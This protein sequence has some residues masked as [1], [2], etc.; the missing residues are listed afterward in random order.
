MCQGTDFGGKDTRRKLLD[1]NIRTCLNACRWLA[2]AGN[3]AAGDGTSTPSLAET[4]RYWTHAVACCAA[5][6]AVGERFSLT[7]ESLDRLARILPGSV[8]PQARDATHYALDTRMFGDA[9][10]ELRFV[11]NHADSIEDASIDFFEA[12]EATEIE[13][14]D[15][16]PRVV[17]NVRGLKAHGVFYTPRSVAERVL[18]AAFADARDAS[19]GGGEASAFPCVLDPAA[20]AGRFLLAA[21]RCLNR[22][23]SRLEGSDPSR[24]AESCLFGVDINPRAVAFART[25]LYLALV[26]ARREHGESDPLSSMP[27][28]RSNIVCGDPL[29]APE[30]LGDL[31]LER[32]SGALDLRRSFPRVFARAEGAGFDV[33]VANPPY[34]FGEH[35][36]ARLKEAYRRIYCGAGRQFDT[37]GLFLERAVTRWLR[38]QGRYAF[39]VPDAILVREQSAYLRRLLVEEGGVDGCAHLGDVFERI[40][41]DGRRGSLGVSVV[42]V[43][44]S[45][46]PYSPRRTLR[47]IGEADEDSGLPHE[48]IMADLLCRFVIHLSRDDRER[49]ESLM[50]AGKTVSDLL[51]PRGIGRGEETGKKHLLDRVSKGCDIAVIAGENVEPF[52][53]GPGRRYVAKLTPRKRRLYESPKILVVKTG[54]RLVAAR[55]DSGAACL[56]SVYCLLPKDEDAAL[57]LE[58]WLNSDLC[59]WVV[60]KT[61]TAYKKLMPQVTQ[62]ELL[63]LPVP[64]IEKRNLE[65]LRLLVSASH[66]ES[67]ARDKRNVVITTIRA[68]WP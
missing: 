6:D 2:Q 28:L 5:F 27:D 40:D 31:L 52:R 43:T 21:F 61:I 32:P 25:V 35:L 50:E 64:K 58:A 14:R 55:D 7:E 62:G 24:L 36:D 9:R 13:W 17:P 66:E 22:T 60:E 44:G 10:E 29:V 65:R 19:R 12:S 33:V 45:R 47:R 56:Q 67:D 48:E 38:P 16:E 15:G 41:V 53:I 18:D 46:A 54:R 49:L 1:W 68:F 37:Y 57:L 11:L 20:G 26:R 4:A 63:S 30:E 23:G 51:A 34:R 8:F 59:A 42:I 3:G 39:L